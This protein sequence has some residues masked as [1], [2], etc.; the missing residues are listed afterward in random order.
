MN[1]NKKIIY[2][3]NKYLKYNSI[4]VRNRILEDI[5]FKKKYLRYKKKY[6]NLKNIN[7]YGGSL[8]L[9]KFITNNLFGLAISYAFYIASN[10]NLTNFSLGK[11]QK[12]IENIN[13]KKKYKETIT[14]YT[15]I[16]NIPS[17]LKNDRDINILIVLKNPQEYKYLPDEIKKD[18]YTNITFIR[19]EPFLY[20]EID[21]SLKFNKKIILETLKSF[22]YLKKNKLDNELIKINKLDG[23][24][25]NLIELLTSDLKYDDEILTLSLELNGDI[26]ENLSE[27]YQTNKKLLLTAYKSYESEFL[28]TYDKYG[29]TVTKN[30]K[31]NPIDLLKFTQSK[32]SN[33]EEVIRKSVELNGET[34]KYA[35]ETLKNNREIIIIALGNCSEAIK[36]IS[37]ELKKDKAIL[38]LALK[39]DITIIRS[40]PRELQIELDIINRFIGSNGLALEF[41]S[42]ELKRDRILVTKAVTSNGLALE[43]ASE[44]LKRDRILVTK[45]VTSNGLA[46][47]FVPYELKRNREIV[48]K[49]VV[50]NGLALEFVPDELRDRILVTKAVVSNGLA[51]E[52]VPDEFK[53]DRNIVTKAVES[54][55]LAL[56]FASD[57]F[58][59]DSYIVTKAIISNE[60]AIQ[61]ASKIFKNNLHFI[62]TIISNPYKNTILF[63][64]KNFKNFNLSYELISYI[65]KRLK[66]NKEILFSLINKNFFACLYYN[67]IEHLKNIYEVNSL[68]VDKVCKFLTLTKTNLENIFYKKQ[69]KITV[70]DK[71]DSKLSKSLYNTKTYNFSKDRVTEWLD[72]QCDPDAKLIGKFMIDITRHVTYTEFQEKLLE[73]IIKIPKST[74]NNKK[75]V[76]IIPDYDRYKSNIWISSILIDKIDTLNL[77]INILDIIPLD[78]SNYNKILAYSL[79]YEYIDFIICDDASYSGLQ[80]YVSIHKFN[81]EHKLKIKIYCLIP[82][83]SKRAIKRLSEIPNLILLYSD[84]I[85]NIKDR[86]AGLTWVY[87]YNLKLKNG[88]I[89]NPKFD[90]FNDQLSFYLKK[91]FPN[92]NQKPAD[93]N[94]THYEL[95]NNIPIYFDHKIADHISSFPIIYHYGYIKHEGICRPKNVLLFN[96]CD[97]V[98]TL[99]GLNNKEYYE[100]QCIIPFYK[101]IKINII[102]EIDDKK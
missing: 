49:A 70:T 58:K 95:N 63:I 93:K 87:N 97:A 25:I 20:F 76:I 79:L 46:L 88:D 67:D 98:A 102:L 92:L 32:F 8:D 99:D 84:I 52:F 27:T 43:F 86:C 7:Q 33:D 39:R 68:L 30:F 71:K 19:R 38:F 91:H 28:I 50:S 13:I 83:V 101:T 82:F 45:A 36:Y 41:A 37:D 65:P 56:E 40:I 6:I 96:N 29:R 1:N 42:E 47:E 15:K 57:E 11:S 48:T 31:N 55:G 59:N 94:L 12:D 75:Y 80:L 21:D 4:S 64:I 24:G 10:I 100:Q 44:E 61:F 34:I 17:E 54:N 16:I 90:N 51:L 18:L 2:D 85:Q 23:E 72:K 14:E 77:D 81:E 74:L 3:E 60:L 5:F 89:I 53:N 22:L 26:F 62:T 69:Y 35:S 73:S 78:D 9:S 66:M